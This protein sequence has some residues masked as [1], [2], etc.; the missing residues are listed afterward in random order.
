MAGLSRREIAARAGVS[1]P[2][3]A[4]VGR[5][6]ALIVGGDGRIDPREP[7]NREWIDLRRRGIDGLG[8]LLPA[9]RRAADASFDLAK[10]LDPDF[11]LT[12]W[13]DEFSARS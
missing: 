13:L 11:N 5:T 1:Q 9:R 7:V 4:H 2:A 8:R 10:L 3:V 6:G 12:A